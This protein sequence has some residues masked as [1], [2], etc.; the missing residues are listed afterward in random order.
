MRHRRSF[1]P[2]R[3]ISVFLLIL[4]VILSAFELVRY[5]RIRS[6]Y[7]PGLAIAGIPV[8]GLDAQQ[9]NERLLQAYTAV[10]VEIH[11]RDAVL[12]IKPSAV[13]FK[14]D[15]ESMIAAADLERLRQPFW[16]GFWDFL[17]NRFPKPNPVPL[18]ASLSE[19][20]VREILTSEVA[21]RYDLPPSAGVPVPGST[22]FQSGQAGTVLDVERAVGLISDAFRSPGARSVALTYSRVAPPRPSL[23]NLKIL[24][25]QVIQTANYDGTLELYMDDLQ[26]GDEIHFAYDK[27]QLVKPDIAFTA[28]STMKIPI[29]ISVFRHKKFPQLTADESNLITLMIDYSDNATA[30]KLMQSEL[31]KNTGPLVVTQDMKELG[32]AN[33]FLAGYF[34][35]GAPLL[36]RIQSPANQRSDISADP[37]PYNQTT[38]VE[39][40]LLLEDIYNCSERG[41]GTFAAVYG[42]FI[43]QDDCKQMV[44]FLSKNRNGVLLEAGLPE[45]MRIAHKHGWIIESDN[46]MHT[47]SDAGIIYSPGGNYILSVYLHDAKQLLWDPA[48]VMVGNLSQA[49]YNY[50][51]LSK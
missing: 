3:W 10:P 1:L 36:Q 4:A 26:T 29:M 28:A 5:S 21:A 25:Q 32:L 37:D 30:D 39:M 35:A 51:N 16:T 23:D 7:P 50:F 46:L 38:P 34:F 17:W 40:G 24:L 18:V 9:A 6:N 14:L 47:I 49:V 8:G 31:D 19:N 41:G 33:T 13:D 12:Q 22:D 45:G 11:Y 27:S 15:T 2:L 48:N 42:G 44:A 20:R 43:S